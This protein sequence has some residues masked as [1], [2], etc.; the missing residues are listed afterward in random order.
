MSNLCTI[1]GS[2]SPL[3]SMVGVPAAGPAGVLYL[4]TQQGEG[5]FD[6]SLNWPRKLEEHMHW[7]MYTV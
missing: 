5:E 4:R 2:A 1:S 6:W 3:G 7:I